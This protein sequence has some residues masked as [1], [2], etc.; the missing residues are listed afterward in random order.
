VKIRRFCVRIASALTGCTCALE[1]R[2][3][4]GRV[5]WLAALKLLDAATDA[6]GAFCCCSRALA[7]DCGVA[8]RIHLPGYTPLIDGCHIA[9]AR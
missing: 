6:I 1:R 2:C 8:R 5:D 4:A 3:D 9:E 7:S